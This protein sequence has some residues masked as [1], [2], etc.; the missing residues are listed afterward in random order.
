MT[1]EMWKMQ[2]GRM[3]TLFAERG[4]PWLSPGDE[5]VLLDYLAAH[6]GTS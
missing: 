5:R 6:A 2:I 3:Q 1:L 4:I